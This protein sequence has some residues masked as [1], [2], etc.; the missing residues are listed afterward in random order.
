MFCVWGFGE[1]GMEQ[2]RLAWIYVAEEGLELLI[3]LSPCHNC[4]VTGMRHYAW[5]L[6]LFL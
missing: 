5:L 1:Q 6:M 3:L 4:W 2:L